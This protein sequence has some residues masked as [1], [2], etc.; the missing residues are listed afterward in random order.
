MFSGQIDFEP[1]AQTKQTARTGALGFTGQIGDRTYLRPLAIADAEELCALVEANRA[2]LREWLPWLDSSRTVA[3]SRGFIQSSSDRAQANNGF[4]LAIL[5]ND[6]IAGIVGLNYINWDN[7]LSGIGYWLAQTHQRK[8]IMTRSCHAVLDH[9]FN[10]LEL[11]RIDIRCAPQNVQSQA[12]AKRLG[13]LYEGT[14]RDAERLYDCFVDHQVYSM[15]RRE[16]SKQ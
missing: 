16:W 13:L 9:G 2:Y 10:I 6:K 3:D 7:R 12:V 5:V 14:L 4:T 8:G 11:N 1:L 15:L